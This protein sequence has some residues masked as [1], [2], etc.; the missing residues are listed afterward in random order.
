MS[1]KCWLAARG[2][3]YRRLEKNRVVDLNP[4]WETLP[5]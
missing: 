3:V 4:L 5:G 2:A 1:A